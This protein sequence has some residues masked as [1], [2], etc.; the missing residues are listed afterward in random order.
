MS[1]LKRFL[2]LT[3]AIVM[4]VSG[5]ALNVGAAPVVFSDIDD[6]D[7]AE[8][9]RVLTELGIVAGYPDG[10]FRG[11]ETITREQ[12][13]V[14]TA[15]I[16][17]GRPDWFDG[18]AAS[19][20]FADNAEISEWAR[21]AV[22]YCFDR[23]IVNGKGNNMFA[24]KDEVL[25]QEAIAMLVRSLGYTGLIYPFGE[26]LKATEGGPGV[27]GQVNLLG[28]NAIFDVEEGKTVRPADELT[29]NG[30][31]KLLYNYLFGAEF[32]ETRVTTGAHNA[33][34]GFQELFTP[35]LERFGIAEV[36]GYITGVPSWSAT[37]DI[38]DY[39][40]SGIPATFVGQ[41]PGGATGRIN[42]DIFIS[43][44]TND[45]I[46]EGGLPTG[47]IIEWGTTGVSMIKADLGFT[48][49]NDY[50]LGLKI[51]FYTNFRTGALR[52]V[53]AA[54]VVGVKSEIDIADTG[55]DARHGWG[56]PVGGPIEGL[57]SITLGDEVYNT[58]A[59][60]DALDIYTFVDNNTTR[61]A[62]N[63][64]NNGH[65]ASAR[66]SL[67]R[68]VLNAQAFAENPNFRLQRVVNGVDSFGFAEEFYVFRPFEVAFFHE[69]QGWGD[70]NIIFRNSNWDERNMG[71]N[72]HNT[73]RTGA[74]LGMEADVAFNPGNAYF[75]T[76]YAHN[77]DR[78]R[79]VLD[80]YGQLDA[81]DGITV[82]ARDSERARFNVPSIE[83]REAYSFWQAFNN[84]DTRLKAAAGAIGGNAHLGINH[85]VSLYMAGG[86]PL[87]S[88]T[89]DRRDPPAARSD[90]G[91]VVS[92]GVADEIIDGLVTRTHNIRVLNLNTNVVELV[93]VGVAESVSN[94]NTIPSE[95]HGVL[96]IHYNLGDY[97][98]LGTGFGTSNARA[99]GIH[100][101]PVFGPNH[102]NIHVLANTAHEYAAFVSSAGGLSTE[103]VLIGSNLN[104]NRANPFGVAPISFLTGNPVNGVPIIN[105]NATPIADLNANTRIVVYSTH[106]DYQNGTLNANDAARIYNS[107]QFDILLRSAQHAK[108]N[109]AIVGL[110]RGDNFTIY[111]G[112][113]RY[114]FVQISERHDRLNLA[115]P[116]VTDEFGT[117]MR[118]IPDAAG[119]RLSDGARLA[120]FEVAV[121]DANGNATFRQAWRAMNDGEADL[122]G[123]F[124]RLR[125]EEIESSRGTETWAFDELTADANTGNF[126]NYLRNTP[127]RRNNDGDFVAYAS[128]NATTAIGDTN[129]RVAGTGIAAG[130]ERISGTVRDMG[131]RSI[132]VDVNGTIEAFGI[133][134]KALRLIIANDAGTITNIRTILGHGDWRGEGNDSFRVRPGGGRADD[135]NPHGFEGFRG[136]STNTLRAVIYRD[137]TTGKIL[138]VQLIRVVP[139]PPAT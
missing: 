29:R 35:V 33:I 41:Q 30:M 71:G 98:R 12:F 133:A 48:Q 116:H 45:F 38:R 107:T 25:L 51:V 77:A 94:P 87:L 6:A 138:S 91:V 49:D 95:H 37:L 108:N 16:H 119:F 28:S 99:R 137:S 69:V 103:N 3:I 134:D 4:I 96:N 36:V 22:L 26:L 63:A 139:T 83:G 102:P 114:V 129:N 9:M 40:Q 76:Q 122:V 113:A 126:G 27:R 1:N 131:E 24:P 101:L 43:F 46:R 66:H 52:S 60:V 56:W 82:L 57:N 74:A 105:G 90:Y 89:T 15:R 106:G 31:A 86:V 20:P 42:H 73:R 109:L 59:D 47:R 104:I 92:R 110:R 32:Y 58:P 124:V 65:D 81:I 80:V 75:F 97:V 39:N 54:K 44:P 121:Y 93:R 125:T 128:A 14:F 13:A 17:S 112:N 118:T 21:A 7:L 132:L 100:V 85:I 50:L 78:N 2:A 88:R 55:V 10:T 5:M 68:F 136:P 135:A 130:I 79:Y 11:D 62:R 111:P 72:G 19:T 120:F 67:A 23:G 115:G 84:Q 127:E 123:S 64:W 53:P 18:I 70:N 8:A 61:L 117:I 34:T